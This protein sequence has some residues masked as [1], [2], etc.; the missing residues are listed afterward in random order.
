MTRRGKKLIPQINLGKIYST[1]ISNIK[2]V[3]DKKL[4]KFVENEIQDGPQIVSIPMPPYRHAFFIDVRQD[5]IMISD[6]EEITSSPSQYSDVIKLV[7]QKYNRKVEYY[8]I[9]EKLLID[10]KIHNDEHGGGGCS[11][12]I[13]SWIQTREEYKNYHI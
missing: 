5:K 10:A 3:S 4:Q 9:D 12:Y 2:P 8:P 13:F 1:Y 6:W 11:Y 7:E